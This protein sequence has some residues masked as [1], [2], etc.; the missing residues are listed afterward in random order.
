MYLGSS[1]FITN[2]LGRAEQHYL[3]R[4]MFCMIMQGFIQSKII[5]KTSIGIQYL[6]F[7]ELWINQRTSEF[8]SPYKFSAKELDSEI[9]YQY[10]M[11]RAGWN[12]QN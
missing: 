9:E 3:C 7:G 8:D 4:S 11:S 12:H 2:A 6:P 5:Y 10:R 1:S